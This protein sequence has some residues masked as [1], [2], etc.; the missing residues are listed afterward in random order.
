MDLLQDLK[1]VPRHMFQNVFS[2]FKAYIGQTLYSSAAIL[3][4]QWSIGP[5]LFFYIGLYYEMFG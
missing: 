5:Q 4:S 1:H 3:D 2:R